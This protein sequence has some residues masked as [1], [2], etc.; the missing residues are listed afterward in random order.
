MSSQGD[1]KSNVE[2]EEATST[3]KMLKTTT[4]KAEDAKDDASKEETKR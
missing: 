1:A 3:T 2:R 4:E